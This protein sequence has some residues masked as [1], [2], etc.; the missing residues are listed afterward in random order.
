M[1]KDTRKDG[2]TAGIIDDNLYEWQVNLFGFDVK[3]PIG[4]DL[5]EYQS[6]FGLDH[7]ELNIKFPPE[8]PFK[9]P[10]VRVVRPGILGGYVLEGGALCMELLT[11]MGWSS[12]VL[13]RC[14]ARTNLCVFVAYV[15]DALI[16]QLMATLVEGKARIIMQPNTHYDERVARSTFD[17]IVE[18][19]K[20][21]GWYT[22]P[23]T[24]G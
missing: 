24:K 6:R 20:R 4:R 3:E 5:K 1:K 11:P 9:P 21:D 13:P 17:Y 10:F 23:K 16:P 19:H 15:M 2:F 8:Y 14:R 18:T 12:G 7:I 22:P